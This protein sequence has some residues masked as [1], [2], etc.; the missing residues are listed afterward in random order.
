MQLHT[1]KWTSAV[2]LVLVVSVGVNV[3]QAQKIRALVGRPVVASTVI[4]KQ[5]LSIRGVSPEGAPI[6][7]SLKSALPTVLY[8]F[9]SSCGW[10]ERNWRNIEALAE[11]AQG[12][13]RVVALTTEKGIQSYLRKR[14]ISVDVVEQIELDVERLLNLA[15]TPKTIAVG[16]DGVV[17]HEWL[18]AYQNRIGRQ[19]EELFVVTLPGITPSLLQRPRN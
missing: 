11:G 5:V 3:L 8:H 15:G 10:C 19:I 1:R 16:S 9:S 14:G 18:G 7:I 13:Y 2:M 12:R 17:T 6:D 4:G